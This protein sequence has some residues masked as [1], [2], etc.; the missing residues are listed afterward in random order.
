MGTGRKPRLLASDQERLFATEYLVDYN[1]FAAAKR[2]GYSDS[3]AEHAVRALVGKPCIRTIIETALDARARHAL[4]KADRIVEELAAIAFADPAALFNHDG[5]LRPLRDIPEP[6]RRA[7]ATVEFK[8]G[9]L[10]VKF[11]DKL[12]ALELLARH[13]GIAPEQLTLNANLTVERR[14]QDLTDEQLASIMRIIQA[15]RAGLPARTDGG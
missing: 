7:M 15:Q 5:T 4:I 9:S 11:A 3:I 10:T 6:T 1:A 14:Y 12:R 8:N 2:A 13:L